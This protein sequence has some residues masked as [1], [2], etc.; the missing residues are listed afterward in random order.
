MVDF[1]FLRW[2]S[3][4]DQPSSAVSIKLAVYSQLLWNIYFNDYF[5]Y[6]AS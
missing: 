5:C 3:P 1:V 6:L 4:P 2:V